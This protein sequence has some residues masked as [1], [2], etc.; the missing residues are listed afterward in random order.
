MGLSQRLIVAAVSLSLVTSLI[1]GLPP[2]AVATPGQPTNVSA[3]VT[4]YRA[5]SPAIAKASEWRGSA[6][7][8]PKA[9][10]L[11][12]ALPV[13]AGSVLGR[14]TASADVGGLPVKV[15][16]LVDQ[17]D[18]GLSEQHMRRAVAAVPS[19]VKL[20]LVSPATSAAAGYPLALRLSRSDGIVHAAKVR[21]DV[22]YSAFRYAYGASWA[23]RLVW[24]SV[25]PCALA[26]VVAESCA[27]AVTLA[28]TNNSRAGVISAEVSLAA[29]GG[30]TM[31][32]LSSVPQSE[33]GDFRKTDLKESGSWAAGGSSG[34]FTYSY[35]ITVPP[36]PGELV[37]SVALSY[38]SGSVDGQTAGQNTQSSMVGEGWS[39]H[40]G[41]IERAV[42]PCLDDQDA[43]HPAHWSLTSG[44]LGP[45]WRYDNYQMSLAGHS[46]ELVPTVV[47]GI[48]KLANDDG[49]RVQLLTDGT[50]SFGGER[51]KVTTRDGTQ[52]WFGMTRL[53]GW[54]SGKP[55]TN[56]ILTTSI[57][58]NH[59]DEPCFSSA[60]FY[61]SRCDGIAYRWQLDH[62][63][64]L[65]GNSM[66]LL[67]DREASRFGVITPGT[68]VRSSLPYHRASFLR[69][70]QYGTRAGSEATATAKAIVEFTPAD[71]C[72]TAACTTHDGVNWPDT[73]WDLQCDGGN[74]ENNMGP[75]FW[76]TRRL[77]KVATKIWDTV[78]GV[79]VPVDE[80]S[81]VQSFPDTGGGVNLPPVMW[82]DNITRTGR[83]AGGSQTLPATVFGGRFDNNRADFDPNATMAAHNKR[84][85]N[86]IDSDT[87]GRIIVDY[88]AM[89]AGCQFGQAIWP[90]PESNA[91]RCYPQWYT[92]PSGSSHWS[93]WHKMVVGAVRVQDRTGGSPEVKTAYSFASDGSSNK[94]LWAYTTSIWAASKK[95]NSRWVGYSTVT[96]TVGPDSGTRSQSKT[97]YYRGLDGDLTD[98]WFG[99]EQYNLGMVQ[100]LF[101]DLDGDGRQDLITDVGSSHQLWAYRNQ[102]Y[103]KA[104][105]FVSWDRRLLTSG[106][107]PI[108][109]T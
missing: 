108:S 11:S 30:E 106:F 52:Y 78:S 41:F 39:Y 27:E 53:P 67:Y 95:T 91:H 74:C 72:F 33:A 70:I 45:C 3:P 12:V 47:A 100:V 35:P 31:V 84:R 4:P 28:T 96:T 102:G 43:A 89:D 16:P 13:D 66:S 57:W 40:P 73:A 98:V 107:G 15:T 17:T 37:P 99:D 54:V 103:D 75:S 104:E 49:T 48:W 77:S 2:T 38:S 88:M 59:S 81:L 51:W 36:V 85:I 8:W 26:V 14:G 64:D 1:V 82:L 24:K 92:N 87:G 71:R 6:P 44:S 93:W 62:V 21:V 23:T 50:G 109:G 32:V 63:V 101:A 69:K 29:V 19:A 25:R 76:S 22:D 10:A 86:Q 61:A 79:Y 60:S 55:E 46:G 80:W 9:A 34:D 94:A 105:V 20:E 90:D 7:V 5:D 65:H 42:R 18:G 97:L 58:A 68:G 83:S 56:S